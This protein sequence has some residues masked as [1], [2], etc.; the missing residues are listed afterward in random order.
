M[1]VD[2][3]PLA[4][5]VYV[6]GLARGTSSDAL[7]A[8]FAS[9]FAVVHA[10]AVRTFG[11]V[12]FSNPELATLATELTISI[13]GRQLHVALSHS[14]Y[15]SASGE[16]R[17]APTSQSGAASC[18]VRIPSERGKQAASAVQKELLATCSTHTAT[19]PRVHVP[20]KQGGDRHRGF[21]FVQC[22]GA[23][24]A[25]ALLA[26]LAASSEWVAELVRKRRGGGKSGGGRSRA[27]RS[28]R[29]RGG[30]SRG[31][32]PDGGSVGGS[33]GSDARADEEEDGAEYDEDFE[34][35]EEEE[36]GRDEA[37]QMAVADAG[38][39]DACVE[40]MASFVSESR[41]WALGVQSFLVEHCVGFDAREENKL[42]WYEL[43]GTLTR[44]MES[45]LEAELAKLG[46]PVAD[47]VARLEA[48]PGSKAASELVETVLAMDDFVRFKAMMLQLKEEVVEVVEEEVMARFSRGD[49][50]L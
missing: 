5:T 10:V 38:G 44:R 46:V 15:E 31:S 20:R 22:A 9:H 25:A 34:S 7:R 49:R 18:F 33:G 8:A 43:H 2:H 4:T 29:R 35:E 26:G 12:T 21:A 41:E 27:K 36:W 28:G 11:F 19:P 39:E 48:S 30:K 24:D 14:R 47:F 23:A 1:T 50:A 13:E 45:L 32:K 40:A 42:E 16:T 6:G 37:A 17:S 3:D